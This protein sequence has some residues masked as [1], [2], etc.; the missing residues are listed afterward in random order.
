LTAFPHDRSSHGPAFVSEYTVFDDAHTF[1]PVGYRFCVD[2]NLYVGDFN[3]DLVDDIV[4]LRLDG[5]A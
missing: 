4:C 5:Y 2:G 1:T 3:A